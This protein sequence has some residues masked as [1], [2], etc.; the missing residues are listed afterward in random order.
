MVPYANAFLR[1]GADNLL[2]ALRSMSRYVPLAGQF[3]N[4]R[5]W[6]QCFMLVLTG[7][8]MRDLDLEGRRMAP[9]IT[10]PRY[11]KELHV[12]S[13]LEHHHCTTVH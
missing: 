4:F 3:I 13:D 11:S 10:T 1:Q 9:I 7:S 12:I 2:I 8:L 6:F 5:F